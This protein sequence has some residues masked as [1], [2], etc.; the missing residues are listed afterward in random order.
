MNKDFKSPWSVVCSLPSFFRSM[1]DYY[2]FGYPIPTRTYSSGYRYGFNGQEGDGEIYGDKLNY[3]FQYRMYDARIGRFWS[4]DPLNV[5][6]PSMSPYVY[7][8]NNPVVLVDPDGRLFGDFFNINGKHL[9]RDNDP[10]NQLIYIVTD[11]AS[12]NTITNNNNNGSTT[13][14]SDVSI[15][16]TAT[17][18]VFKATYDVYDRTLQNGGTCEESSIV[19]TRLYENKYNII[20]LPRG[21]CGADANSSGLVWN[22]VNLS[23]IYIHSHPLNLIFDDFGKYIGFGTYNM[24]TITQK[25]N[26]SDE[27]I[28]PSFTLNVIVGQ[29]SPPLET[30]SP[31]GVNE[32]SFMKG[33]IGAQ[34]YDSNNKS[35]LKINMNAIIKILEHYKN[36]NKVQ[37]TE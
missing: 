9:G 35:I 16:V 30:K 15:Q 5:K 33:Y 31:S 3:A 11:N 6:Y 18:S 36:E 14:P 20:E 10:N 32:N 4:V 2:P 34:F 29:M 25:G 37:S 28:F 19:D 17:R 26:T 24:S 1:T 23:F 21:T 22:Y 27:Y 13:A 12:E 7:C 8:A